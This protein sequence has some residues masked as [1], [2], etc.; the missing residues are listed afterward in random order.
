[1]TGHHRARRL[2]LQAL[3]AL[4]VQGTKARERVDYFIDDSKEPP[5]TIAFARQLLAKAVE[6]LAPCDQFLSRHA[7]HWEMSRLALV[8]RNILRLAVGEILSGRTPMK[9]AITEAL[10]LAKEF[11]TAESPRFINGVLDAVAKDILKE[12]SRDAG[13]TGDKA[14]A[15]EERDEKGK[16]N[17]DRG[18]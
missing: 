1:M 6:H 17:G 4:D 12:T 3:C 15:E 5:Q 18:T 9:V 13:D 11:S 14:K 10:R 7:R 2:A 8:D 16:Q